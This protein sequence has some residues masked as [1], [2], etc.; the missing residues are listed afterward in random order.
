MAEKR[1]Q[2]SG[3]ANP[4]DSQQI[5]Q[6]LTKLHPDWQI[7]AD[8]A[9]ISRDF[10]FNDFHQTMAFANAVAW[11]AHQA[12][13]HP[14]LTLSYRQCRVHYST[15]SVSGLSDKDFNCARQIDALQA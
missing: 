15:H 14:T 11:I 1:S 6:E 2:T 8:L 10:K 9:G 3:N 12:D 7:D 4:L 5:R 13:H